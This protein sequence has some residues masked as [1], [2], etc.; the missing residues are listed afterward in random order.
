MPRTSNIYVRVEPNIKQQA[1]K[2]LE[3]LGIP[4]SNAVSIFFQTGN[5]AKRITI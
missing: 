3:K 4:M 5:H 2:I 1:V